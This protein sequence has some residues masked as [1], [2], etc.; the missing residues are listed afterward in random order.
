MSDCRS[1]DAKYLS[2]ISQYSQN[3]LSLQMARVTSDYLDKAPSTNNLFFNPAPYHH[4]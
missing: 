1:K 4:Q 3:P 2:E